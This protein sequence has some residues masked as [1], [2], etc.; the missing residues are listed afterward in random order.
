MIDFDDCG[1]GWFAYD[2]AA[3]ISFLE[4]EPYVPD[5]A[6]AWLAGYAAVA[7]LPPEAEEILPHMIM[8][9]RM[10]LTAWIASH[11]ETPT[12]QELVADG[13]TRGTVELAERH[14]SCV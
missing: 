1:F 5:L 12:A 3:A 7:P 6:D 10:L 4:H 8:L 11:A 9:R 2:F 13:Y 14:L